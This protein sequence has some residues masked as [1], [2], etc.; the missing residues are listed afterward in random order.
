MNNNYWNR[1]EE[2]LQ[3]DF[4]FYVVDTIY[5][6]EHEFKICS[7]NGILNNEL[8]KKLGLYY[9][10]YDLELYPTQFIPKE[11][12]KKLKEI[13]ERRNEFLRFREDYYIT[14]HDVGKYPYDYEISYYEIDNPNNP[15]DVTVSEFK[16]PVPYENFVKVQSLD[17]IKQ[18]IHNLIRLN[19]S[20][21]PAN[22][23]ILINKSFKYEGPPDNLKLCYETLIK[24][25]YIIEDETKFGSVFK[26]VFNNTKVITQINWIGH[27]NSLKYF[28]NGCEKYVLM[29]KK[30]VTTSK[31]FLIYKSQFT[32]YQI[33]TNSAPFADNSGEITNAIEHLRYEYE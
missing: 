20:F 25:G 7:I 1:I 13:L 19:E 8:Y 6:Q 29:S 10:E 24:A 31:C 11:R 5:D 30:W 33:R 16:Y 12:L 32:A 21:L 23:E 14:T 4:N 18:F 27:I 9:K 22:K 26:P 28:I 2:F 15:D 3:K 17:I